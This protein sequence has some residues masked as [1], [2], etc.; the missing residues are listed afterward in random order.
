M[1]LLIMILAIPL[2][3]GNLNASTCY[4]WTTNDWSACSVTACGQTGTQNRTVSCMSDASVYVADAI[5][6]EVK[7][8]TA[9]SCS[10]APC[11][12]TEIDV[13]KF[14]ATPNDNTD[15]TL[16]IQRAINAVTTTLKTVVVPPG[17][18]RVNGVASSST[19]GNFL[20]LKSNMHFKMDPLAVLQIIPNSAIR[21]YGLATSGAS[22]VEISGGTIVGD[23][24]THTFT[25]G[26]THEWGMCLGVTGGSTNVKIHDTRVQDCTGD[27]IVTGGQSSGITIERVVSTN[28]RRQ[29]LSLTNS[30]NVTVRDSEFSYTNGTAPEAGIDIEPDLPREAR[31]IVIEN[32]KI[33]HNNKVGVLPYIQ[34]YGLTIRNNEIYNN[35]HGIYVRGSQGAVIEGNTIK[36]NK[37]HGLRFEG[38]LSGQ[39]PTTNYTI[40]NNK[41]INNHTNL[42]GLNAGAGAL[43]SITGSTSNDSVFRNQVQISSSCCGTLAKPKFL[44]NQYAR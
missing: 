43:T 11:P 34:S 4:S 27:G 40:S 1:K 18:Y 30:S 8:L 16:A 35:N 7:P 31:N 24:K 22:N 13:T 32:N 42:V 26:S 41:F 17:T 38:Q 14:G 2:I 39:I 9:Q 10:T 21:Y 12:P 6:A 25:S 44:T 19:S 20:K 23:R 15:D 3:S 37:V 28:N 33:H 29:G 36:H 5:C